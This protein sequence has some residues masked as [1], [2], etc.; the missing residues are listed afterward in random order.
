M[1]AN[2]SSFPV[3]V[4]NAGVT[5]VVLVDARSVDVFTSMEIAPNA[6]QEKRRSPAAVP[7]E[8]VIASAVVSFGCFG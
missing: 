4:E 6:I 7:K 5:T 8:R 3:L 1:N 2:R